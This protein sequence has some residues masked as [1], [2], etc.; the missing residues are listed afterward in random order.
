MNR[1][2]SRVAALAIFLCLSISPVSMAAPPRDRD[3][4]TGPGE[5]V[6]RIVQKIKDLFRGFTSQEDSLYPPVPKP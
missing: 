3:A 2:Y 6:V 4:I 5:R 1:T